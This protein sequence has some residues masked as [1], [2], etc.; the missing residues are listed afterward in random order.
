MPE[1]II[2]VLKNVCLKLA[3]SF[4]SE[5]MIEWGIFKGAELLVAKTE[6][7]KDDEWLKAFKEQYYKIPDKE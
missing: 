2:S 1:F 5:K 3:V 6:T 7:D 4:F